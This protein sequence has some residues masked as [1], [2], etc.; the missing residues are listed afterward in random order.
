[1][2]IRTLRDTLSGQISY[3]EFVFYSLAMYLNTKQKQS[4]YKKIYS[5]THTFNMLPGL[6]LGINLN[7]WQLID[8][9]LITPIIQRDAIK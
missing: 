2:K 4:Y 9:A 6:L 5:V 7:V 1:M 3:F 8:C